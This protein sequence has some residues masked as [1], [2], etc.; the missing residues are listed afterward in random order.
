[1]NAM[2]PS[3]VADDDGGHSVAAAEAE[4]P[5]WQV[6]DLQAEVA[7]LQAAVRSQ[8]AATSS[9]AARRQ[10]P[11]DFLANL[12]SLDLWKSSGNLRHSASEIDL[13]DPKHEGKSEPW[14]AGHRWR[15][16]RIAASHAQRLTKLAEAQM[17]ASGWDLSLKQF[18]STKG[19]VSSR[20]WLIV[21]Y[22]VVLH[23]ML[24]VS[25]TKSSQPDLDTLCAPKQRL[26]LPG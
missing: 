12:G 16:L 3:T 19:L 7:D 26:Q 21:V 2:L 14:L 8:P 15:W 18:A 10:L 4:H 22:M 20:V 23:L 5:C 9:A 11:S 17:A 24:M 1:M 6:H 13:E 25:F